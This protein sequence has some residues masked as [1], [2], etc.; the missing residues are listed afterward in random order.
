MQA[1]QTLQ[2]EIAFLLFIARKLEE[3]IKINPI[4]KPKEALGALIEGLGFNSDHL[5]L[6]FPAEKTLRSKVSSIKPKLLK[7]GTT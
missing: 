3:I 6:D 4:L 5:P 1:K 2:E 7:D